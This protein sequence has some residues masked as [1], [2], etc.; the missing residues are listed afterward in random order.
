MA[1]LMAAP[2]PGNVRQ[3]HNAIEKAVALCTEPVVPT[4]LMER[5]IAQPAEAHI[6]LDTAKQT[7]E[8]DYV[9]QLLK[10]TR[11]N[12]T[13]AARL[14]QRNRSEFYALLRRHALDPKQFKDSER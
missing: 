7:F 10:Q 5:V 14:A 2:W 6:P 9:V 11:G 3:L 1:L 12:V 13:D 8:R 4:A